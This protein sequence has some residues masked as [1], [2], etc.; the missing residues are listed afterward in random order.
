MSDRAKN[1]KNELVVAISKFPPLV[2]ESQGKYSGFEIDLWETIARDLGIAFQYKM[3]SFDELLAGLQHKKADVA[4]SGITINEKR[5]KIVDFSHHILNSGLLILISKERRHSIFRTIAHFLKSE[6]RKILFGIA[7]IFAFMAISG[8][9]LWVLEFGSGTFNENYLTGVLES[10][11]WAIATMSTVGYGDFVPQTV[12][13][14][15]FASFVIIGGY[16]TFIFLIAELSSLMTS[17]MLKSDI[18]NFNDLGGKIV[19]TERNSTSV[20]ELKRIGAEVVIVYEIEEAYEK[21]EKKDIDA[22]VYDAPVLLNY[23]RNEG[24]NKCKIAGGLFNHQNYG[25]AFR[26]KS[27]L[28]EKINQALLRLREAGNYDML[29]KK[30]FGDYEEMEI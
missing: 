7:I 8:N 26:E 22:I 14:R 25:I 10:F 20:E 17:K 5:E 2:A 29:Y 12:A 16:L 4:L 23:V 15:I 6:Y 18:N 9:V 11:W 30:W 3:T 27:E 28:R 19:A 13:G 21:L 1:R 24:A